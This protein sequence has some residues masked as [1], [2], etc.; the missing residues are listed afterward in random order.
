MLI[1]IVRQEKSSLYQN[2]IAPSGLRPGMA[3]FLILDPLAMLHIVDDDFAAVVEAYMT[4]PQGS[5]IE[6]GEGFRIDPASA[7]AGHPFAM[8]LMHQP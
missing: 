2:V 5:A 6:F 1:S 3:V 4:D 8:T 7:I